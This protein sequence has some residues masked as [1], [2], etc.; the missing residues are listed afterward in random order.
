M[1]V[2]ERVKRNIQLLKQLSGPELPPFPKVQEQRTRYG[3][4]LRE[5]FGVGEW[6]DKIYRF[7]REGVWFEAAEIARRLVHVEE[8]LQR[9]C[10]VDTRRARYYLEKLRE[11][12]ER[13]DWHKV[14]EL[15]SE[16]DTEILAALET[17]K[18]VTYES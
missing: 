2:A 10:G 14:D 6:Q 11:A 8:E 18:Y 5:A 15:I 16:H 9:T 7:A 1:I 4:C 13:K 12:I 3:W 17:A